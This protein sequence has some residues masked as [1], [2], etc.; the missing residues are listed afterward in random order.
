MSLRAAFLMSLLVLALSLCAQARQGAD[1]WVPPPL[2]ESDGG[3]EALRPALEGRPRL[4]QDGQAV[5][6]DLAR[7][8]FEAL[9]PA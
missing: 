9:D 3:F 1:P 4:P 8:V 6:A 2:P 5:Q 7:I